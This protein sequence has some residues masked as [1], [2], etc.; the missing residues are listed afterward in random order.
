MKKL[1]TLFLTVL[2][3]G[4]IIFYSCQKEKSCEGCKPVNKPPIANAGKDSSI[5][6]PGNSIT[7]DGSA[8]TDP[9]GTIT[10]FQWRKISGPASFIL[11]TPGAVQTIADSL[12]KDVYQFELKVTDNS[13]LSAQDTVQITVN[14]RLQTNRPPVANAGADQIIILPTNSSTLD[15][16]ASTDPDNNITNYIWTK[17]SGPGSSDIASSTSVQTQVS[18]LVEGVY[19]F[20]LTVKDNGGLLSKDTM[21]IT[22]TS[23]ASSQETIC[24]SGRPEVNA[25]LI[26][27]GKLSIARFDLSVATAGNKIVFASGQNNITPYGSSFVD[28]Y[29]LTTQ[30][31]STASLQSERF[32]PTVAVNGNKIFFAGGGIFY[33]DSYD[34]TVD[35]YDALTDTWS[36][37]SLKEDN[38]EGSGTSLGDKVLFAGGYSGSRADLSTDLVE[39]YD[40]SKNTWQTAKLS[41]A[42]GDIAAVSMNGK[43]YFAGGSEHSSYPDGTES[44]VIDIYDYAT[45]SW[46][47]SKLSFL[48]TAGT[49]IA[50]G[51][52][53]FWTKKFGS[54]DVEIRNINTGTSRLEQLSRSGPEEIITSVIKDDKIVFIRS[55]S[56]YFDIYN[57]TTN[58]WSVGVLPQPLLSG[59]AVISVNNVIYIAG[60]TAGCIPI[61]NG[62]QSVY[63]NQVW[64]LEF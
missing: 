18:N 53:I 64:K 30:A 63:T 27:V 7:L 28:I 37:S 43:A 61:G 10:A 12:E 42:R 39:I 25:Q 3:T 13:G 17:I 45:N 22:V 56:K 58:E 38:L 32:N 14:D 44:S 33:N 9:D 31:W 20:E 15:G 49:A 48:S 26:P 62:C 47:V 16:S 1:L 40:L 55:N 4:V 2:I 23:N 46:S 5:I 11:K 19:Q 24:V 41:V 21:Q 29:D 59:V 57:T 51:D 36:S 60:G 8:S 52:Q 34:T 35:I 6:L 54:C 50:T